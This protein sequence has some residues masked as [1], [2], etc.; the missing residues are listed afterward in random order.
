MCLNREVV[1]D[2]LHDPC[3]AIP[4]RIGQLATNHLVDIL[5]TIGDRECLPYISGNLHC[6]PEPAGQTLGCHCPLLREGRYE[7]LSIRGWKIW[8]QRS[9]PIVGG[10]CK[11]DPCINTVV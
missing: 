3:E 8:F 2:P 5:C 1:V 11:D 4:I 7:L 9:H 10:H 6:S